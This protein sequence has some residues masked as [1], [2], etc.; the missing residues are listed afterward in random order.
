M[1]KKLHTW[2]YCW[3]SSKDPV[4]WSPD[5]ETRSRM[6]DRLVG[7]GGTLDSAW[8][9]RHETSMALLVWSSATWDAKRSS[10]DWQICLGR[11]RS[12][13]ITTC[14]LLL[15]RQ[16]ALACFSWN[17]AEQMSITRIPRKAEKFTK[18]L[19]FTDSM[20]KRDLLLDFH[21][22]MNSHKR[23]RDETE[24]L[25]CMVCLH[26]HFSWSVL[27]LAGLKQQHMTQQTSCSNSGP[28]SVFLFVGRTSNDTLHKID[29]SYTTE[30]FVFPSLIV[31]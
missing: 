26:F 7:A 9:L 25:L 30:F 18:A 6:V 19:P 11:G 31:I 20:K 3:T 24:S 16:P 10:S 29:Y 15:M 4:L 22:F 5:C 27:K 21:R 17:L 14:C 23:S 1:R 12:K 8:G 28:S 13:R 2:F